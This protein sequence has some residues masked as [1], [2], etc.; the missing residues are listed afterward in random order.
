MNHIILT[1]MGGVNE[2]A[3]HME[4]IQCDLN[5]FLII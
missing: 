5:A 3:K 1:N 2:L 4:L